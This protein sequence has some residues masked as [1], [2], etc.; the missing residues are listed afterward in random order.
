MFFLIFV[1]LVIDKRT[2]FYFKKKPLHCN[3]SFNSRFAFS[4]EKTQKIK[5][6]LKV[7]V[8]SGRILKKVYLLF[9]IIL[10]LGLVKK[11]K[12]S[13]EKRGSY[14][15]LTISLKN[16][17]KKMSSTGSLTIS[18]TQERRSEIPERENLDDETATPMDTTVTSEEQ[19]Q[20]E[21][22]ENPTVQPDPM[23][24][25]FRTRKTI[26][27]NSADG[28]NIIYDEAVKSNF[29]QIILVLL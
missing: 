12:N 19:H 25:A 13:D 23:M 28:N 17:F 1:I 26:V 27:I 7:I 4:Y 15:I 10:T 18:E 2:W 24:R 22:S 6:A 9:T 14:K 5:K 20:E 29:S 8:R 21:K 16:S 11:L 3:F